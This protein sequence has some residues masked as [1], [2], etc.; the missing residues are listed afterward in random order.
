MA[1]K[2]VIFKIKGGI[3]ANVLPIL[4]T[5]EARELAVTTDTGKIFLGCGSGNYKQLNAFPDYGFDGG[6]ILVT[7]AS[8]EITESSVSAVDLQAV[9]GLDTVISAI[10]K[11]LTDLEN[12]KQAKLVGSENHILTY[13]SDNAPHDSGKTLQ[14]ISDEI[15]R[16]ITTHNSDANAHTALRNNISSNASR[17]KTLEDKTQNIGT[18]ADE[19]ADDYRTKRDQDNI[20]S[21]HL[22]KT[23]IKA[24]SNVVVTP[25]SSGNG[26]TISVPGVPMPDK[27]SSLEDGAGAI[28]SE[29][30][31]NASMLTKLSGEGTISAGDIVIFANGYQGEVLN[32]VAASNTYNAVIISVPQDVAWGGITGTIT[33]QADLVGEFSKKVDK[34]TKVAG[35]ALSSD[36]NLGKLSLKKGTTVLLEYDGSAAKAI[37][38]AAL[39]E[40]YT[41]LKVDLVPT[42]VENDLAIFD[43]NGGIKDSGKT[44]NN[45][46]AENDILDGGTL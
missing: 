14:D 44:F 37:D 34:T 8:G 3:E 16:D 6:K 20:D 33:N 40:E 35:K 36:V 25:D 4:S 18:M 17:I 9:D 46:L 23:D 19:S 12:N 10:Q 45:M 27:F 31:Y 7:S 29:G 5:L 13:G 32:Y 11:S 30:S 22:V 26:M 38:L 15:D 42:A 39:I 41:D 1:T 43:A 24:G 21:T 2:Q 28:G